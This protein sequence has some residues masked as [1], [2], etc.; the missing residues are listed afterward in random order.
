MKRL[1]KIG[2]EEH[3]RGDV[4]IKWQP[5][6]NL[7]ATAGKNCLVHIFDRHGQRVDEISLQGNGAITSLDWDMDGDSLAVL[8]E[9]NGI[10]PIWD[11]SSRK[12]LSVDTNLKDP[13][14]MAW[15]KVGPQLAVGTAKGNL[16][17]YNKNTRKKIPVLG[18]HPR[19]ITCGAWSLDNKLALGS[20]DCSL[21]VSNEVGDTLNQTNMDRQPIDMCF[22]AQKKEDPSR[23][24]GE[25]TSTDN[26]IAVNM[27]G[28]SLLLHSVEDPDN[29][30]ELAFQ[31][32]YGKIKVHRWI[33][34]D[35]MLIGFTEGFLVVISTLMSE[36]G[37]EQFS[38]RFHN[39]SMADVAYSS[40]LKRAATAGLGG[41]KVVDMNTNK[42][43]KSDAIAF[44]DAESKI[45][46]LS[47]SPDGQILSVA[48]TV[49]SVFNFLAS[50][51][52]VHASCGPRLVYLSSL[53]EVTVVDA[54]HPK[55][56]PL[57]LPVGIEPTIVALGPGHIAVGMNN[58][59]LFYRVDVDR[60]QQ[61]DER[62][63]NGQVINI[64]LNV[65][66]AA[67][68]SGSQV[69]LNP[70]EPENPPR[71]GSSGPHDRKL[72]GSVDGIGTGQ[73]RTFPE[74][75][76]GAHGKATSVALTEAFL[77]YGTEA[78]T[79]ELF[80][81]PEW[82]ALAGSELRH[83]AAI[84]R[85]WPNYLGTRVVF[86]DDSNVGWLYSPAGDKLTQARAGSREG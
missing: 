5:E 86:M 50:M 6:G 46:C 45:G 48:N 20:V 59:V 31:V 32:K 8:Q 13:T 25:H 26:I 79:L 3:G 24:Q 33:G 27:N 82:A 66:F 2:T 19:R 41:I 36:I 58:R 1:F 9:G 65:D 11:S 78:G 70:I 69:V 21:T 35:Y 71:M 60:K 43:E 10:I 47:W 52:T 28:K 34:G 53:R 74:R 17:I 84:M 76:D 62:E 38:G 80:C 57:T 4:I 73:R 23:K 85:L 49:G 39:G 40:V 7:L 67:V 68:L 54:A 64:C 75:D 77:I 81:L 18:K 51:P 12:I 16:L 30:V 83:S 55:E 44:D 42:E 14:F 61:V 29:P 56:K 72:T 15:S 37:E 63:Y 22:V